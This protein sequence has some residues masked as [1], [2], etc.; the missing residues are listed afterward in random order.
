M[1]C[2]IFV[3]S[4]F[5]E[6]WIFKNLC[7]NNNKQH[8]SHIAVN[9]RDNILQKLHTSAA[10]EMVCCTK[11]VHSVTTW[12]QQGCVILHNNRLAVLTIWKF[13]SRHVKN[14]RNNCKCNTEIFVHRK[15]LHKSSDTANVRCTE[16]SNKS[17]IVVHL[18][19][20]TDSTKPNSY[21]AVL[22]TEKTLKYA[23]SWYQEPT[24]NN[25]N[26]RSANS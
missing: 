2:V 4:K 12:S 24:N 5:T 7:H 3:I 6:M 22:L 8:H 16:I 20:I 25:H 23:E 13:T 19:Y 21:T 10:S 14:I 1:T 18:V 17:F 26:A 15:L 11:Y 9:Y